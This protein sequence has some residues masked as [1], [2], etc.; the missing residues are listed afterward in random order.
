MSAFSDLPSRMYVALIL[1]IIVVLA[2]MFKPVFACFVCASV[3]LIT[4]EIFPSQSSAYQDDLG[5]RSTLKIALR[6]IAMCTCICAFSALTYI[7]ARNPYNVALILAC[8]GLSDIGCYFI[9]SAIGGPRLPTSISAKKTY[10][11]L[12]GGLLLSNCGYYVVS[13]F[14]GHNIQALSIWQVQVVIC[15]AIAGDL[16]ESKFKRLLQIKDMSKLLASHGGVLDRADSMLLASIAFWL[17][18][19]A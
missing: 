7:Y 9:G 4:Q 1:L 17:L 13:H 14:W 8:A 6:I 3:F 11:G 12:M 2:V 5:N 19:Y 10:S 15:A 16:L 18:V